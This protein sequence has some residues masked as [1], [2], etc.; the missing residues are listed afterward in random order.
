MRNRRAVRVLA[1]GLTCACALV[2]VGSGTPAPSRIVDRTFVCNPIA[3]GGV[4]DI[5]V[6]AGPHEPP[7]RFGYATAAHLIVRTG[8]TLPA[9]DLV[10]VR[11]QAQERTG[12]WAPPFPGPAGVYAHA[13]RCKP[14]RS[15]VELSADGFAGPPLRFESDLT[16]GIRG[17]VVVRVRARLAAAADWR[18]AY[19]PF[20]VGARGGVDEAWLAV[21]A[22]RSG[23][24]LAYMTV[25]RAG[26]RLWA[27]PRCS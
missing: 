11:A 12:G 14:T 5:D 16:C 17:S 7:D 25:D 10:F 18:R 21:R 20:L 9:G 26:T 2:A 19:E 24:S 4:S 22:A 23:A 1:I 27:S 6:K 3:Y 15:K 8:T 13:Q